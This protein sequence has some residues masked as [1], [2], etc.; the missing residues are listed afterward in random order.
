MVAKVTLDKTGRLVIPKSVRR[1]LRLEPGDSLA[2]ESQD[3]QMTL[4]PIR[5]PVGL[6]KEHGVWV[7]RSGQIR[8][9]SATEL[10]DQDR[11]MRIREL[12][13]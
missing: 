8:K 7:Y 3:E 10:V 12:I 2:L 5:P 11:E 6:K 4:T 13:G 9:F 1:Q